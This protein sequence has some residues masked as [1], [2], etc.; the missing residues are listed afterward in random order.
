[1]AQEAGVVAILD[2]AALVHDDQAVH[3]RDGREA[4]GDGDH[5]LAGHQPGELLLHGG[6]HLRVQG[7]GGLVEDQDRG[8]L[9][10]HAGEGDTLALAAGQLDAALADPGGIA[11]MTVP[12]AKIG[13]EAVS[14]GHVG[15]D[16]HLVFAG[17]GPAVADVLQNR[18]VQQRG[19]LGHHADLGAQALLRHPSDVLAVDQDA[20]GLQIVEAQQ[21]VDQGRLAR[22]GAAH[23]THLLARWHRQRK[24]LDHASALAVV[25]ADA[26]VADLASGDGQR[27]RGRA[28]DHLLGP[29]DGFHALLHGAQVFEDPGHHP[30]DPA[31]HIVDAQD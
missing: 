5:G 1:M 10:Q 18:A 29:G 22:A 31:G 2:D 6:F 17:L 13:H 19:I 27:A 23:E 3:G 24:V 14:M 7:G 15:G 4:V 8:V 28:V 16:D 9:Q 30:H 25:E 11:A 21:Q 12:V 26:F 20:P